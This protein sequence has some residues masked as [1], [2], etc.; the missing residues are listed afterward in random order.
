M[1]TDRLIQLIVA[2]SVI[3]EE[4]FEYFLKRDPPGES[5]NSG[6]AQDRDS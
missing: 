2:I 3:V 6:A 4:I 1:K 5:D